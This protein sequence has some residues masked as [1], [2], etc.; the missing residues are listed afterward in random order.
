MLEAQKELSQLTK[1]QAALVQPLFAASVSIHA[2]TSSLP[3]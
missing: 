1:K 2:W 3:Q